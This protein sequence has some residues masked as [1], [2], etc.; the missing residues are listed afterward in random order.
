MRCRDRS[1]LIRTYTLLRINTQ[2]CVD[3]SAPHPLL[4][5]QHSIHAFTRPIRWVA[6]QLGHSNPEITLRTYAHALPVD[7][8]DLSFAD[9]GVSER[10]YTSPPEDSA[11]AIDE[12]PATRGRGPSVCFPRQG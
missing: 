3:R 4:Q 11:A 8:A 6:E 10:L 12:A 9:F 7:E 2:E 1:T 5:E